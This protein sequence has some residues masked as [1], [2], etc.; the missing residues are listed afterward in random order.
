MVKAGII[1]SIG[2]GWP[3]VGQNTGAMGE[4]FQSQTVFVEQQLRIGQ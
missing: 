4:S 2:P 3:K 1:M